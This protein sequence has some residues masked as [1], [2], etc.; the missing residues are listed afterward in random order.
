LP[1]SFFG[2]AS[3]STTCSGNLNLATRRPS[4]NSLRLASVGPGGQIALIGGL[5]GF[6]GTIQ[7][8]SLLGGNITVNG[9]YVGSRENFEAMN[10][11]I[12]KHKIKPVIDKVIEFSK[13][14][15]AYQLMES[16]DF[17]GKIVIR[18]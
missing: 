4:R 12:E 11:F 2:S 17:M 18:M 5:G 8:P 15:A 10:A 9:L 13:A 7:A 14:D 3:H 16:G 6:G 1:A